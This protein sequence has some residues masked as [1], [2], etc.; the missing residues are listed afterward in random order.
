MHSKINQPAG[1]PYPIYYVIVFILCLAG[2]IDT[3]YL[4]VSHFKNYTDIAYSSFCAL[5]K[6]IN[7]DTVSQSPWSILLGLPVAYWGFTG[8]L[9]FLFFLV[10]LRKL[11]HSTKSLWIVLFLLALL[12]SMTAIFFAY[13]SS[14]KINAYCIMCLLSYSISFALLFYSWLIRR[15][16]DTDTFL[17]SLKK[18]GYYVIK[19]RLLLITIILL[20]IATLS[21]RI[22]LP[23]YWEFEIPLPADDI[24]HG[25]TEDG[26]PWIGSETPLLTIKEFADYQCFQCYKMHFLLRRLIKRNPGKIRL[27]HYQYPMDNKFNSLVVPEPF[28]VGS[29]K[30]A[31]LAIYAS[32]Q[33]KFWEANDKLY[34]L[35]RQKQAFS[36]TEL[37]DAIGL[38]PGTLASAVNNQQIKLLLRNDIRTGGMA[39]I[40]GTPSYIINDKVYEGYIPSDILLD[41][42]R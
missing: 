41:I 30:M 14:T 19:S 34:E 33:N 29:G 20:T 2:I 9:L 8:Y 21:L 24:P 18:S 1:L 31:L 35:G 38:A 6:A 10:P 15:R 4:A 32:T 13:I 39:G 3:L 26:H 28:H 42:L 16:F 37:G 11:D 27:I 17:T 5:S 7:C 22:T 40:T 23:R 25:I 36:T 12:F